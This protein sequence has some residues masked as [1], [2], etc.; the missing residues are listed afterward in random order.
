MTGSTAAD[1]KGPRKRAFYGGEDQWIPLAPR[2][3]ALR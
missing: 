1:G 3:I 2:M